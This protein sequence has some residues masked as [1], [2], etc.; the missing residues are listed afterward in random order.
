MDSLKL[1]IDRLSQ[2]NFLTNILPGSVLCIVLKYMVGYDLFVTGDWY[3]MGVIFYFVGMVNN[4]FGSIF[5]EWVLKETSFVKFAS[6]DSFVLAEKNDDKISIL[7][8][9]NN[10]FRSYIS[11]CLLSLL[12]FIFKC[13]AIKC[14]WVNELRYIFLLIA[15]LVLFLL[16][17][18]KQT[19]YVLK[20]IEVIK[21]RMM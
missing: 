8:M 10:V 7:S 3:Q 17:Y 18:R 5:V 14:A 6:Y 4:R 19:S 13:I 15:L 21:K 16:S 2:Y 9:E 1:L 11:V 20:R 12:T